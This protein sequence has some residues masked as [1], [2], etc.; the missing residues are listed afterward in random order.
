MKIRQHNS[1]LKPFKL[2]LT[3]RP[4]T[5]REVAKKYGLP[6]AHFRSVTNFVAKSNGTLTDAV[7]LAGSK[8]NS[9]SSQ[10]KQHRHKAARHDIL[11]KGSKRRA[12]KARGRRTT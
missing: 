10:Y 2:K 4:L 8:A 11:L 3:G 6:M 7:P 5:T 9:P 1:K 12:V